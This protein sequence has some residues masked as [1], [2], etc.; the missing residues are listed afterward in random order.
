MI[1]AMARSISTA[2]SS[3][4][5]V[6]TYAPARRVLTVTAVSFLAAFAL[7]V[8][9]ELGRFDAGYDRLAVSQERA[10]HGVNVDRLEKANRELRTRLAELD[11][12]RVG[13]AREQAEVSRSIGDLQAQVARQTQELAF[14][15]GIV[16]QSATSPGV[17][18]QQLRIGAGSKP[19]RY[20]IRMNLVR[21]VRPDDVVTGSLALTAEG[22]KQGQAGGM[23]DMGAL[24]GGKV[25]ELPFT[26]R[27]F[28]NFEQEIT[29]P[30]GFTP[31]RLT[32][33]VRSG[34]KGISPVTQTFP[35]NVDAS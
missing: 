11:T 32:V 13:R 34:K 12:I 3:N 33:E 35:W 7:Y 8:V 20:L 28:Q 21:S 17:R 31:E 14:Y 29:M 26:F 24:T 9:Y 2:T 15:R 16:A 27:Y 22:A 6:R 30:A 18:I 4:I 5:V 23:L 25:R 19:G 1:G 10:E